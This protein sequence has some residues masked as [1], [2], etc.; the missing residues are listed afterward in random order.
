ME[1]SKRELN[2]LRETLWDR[3]SFVEVAETLKVETH[4][5]KNLLQTEQYE[6]N[7]FCFP[8]HFLCPCLETTQNIV[9]LDYVTRLT[10]AEIFSMLWN[11]LKKSRF[12]L[13][14]SLL[15]KKK[16][17]KI[18]RSSKS[19]FFTPTLYNFFAFWMN[20]KGLRAVGLGLCSPAK[21]VKPL[22]NTLRN[23]INAEF[24]L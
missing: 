5:E 18:D 17:E 8:W 3:V 15:L 23:E 19:N 22:G 20:I 7:I 4:S 2:E 6:T 10:V 21:N 24:I 11:Y 1:E 14:I 12:C 16:C 9:S 13:K